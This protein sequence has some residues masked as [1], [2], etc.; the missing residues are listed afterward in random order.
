MNDDRQER[1]GWTT[2]LTRLLGGVAGGEPNDVMP[3]TRSAEAA[4]AA[5]VAR[6]HRLSQSE[7]AELAGSWV[8]QSPSGRQEAWA[9]AKRVVSERGRSPVLDRA[10]ADITAWAGLDARDFTGID[11]LLGRPSPEVE[12]RRLAALA[13]IDATVGLLAAGELSEA[14]RAVLCGPWEQS[15][16]RLNLPSSDPTPAARGPEL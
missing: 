11:G 10:R 16:D 15:V 7:K 14:E 2:R 8:E 6:L 12:D 4:V 13:A 1:R 3:E 9:N 5:V